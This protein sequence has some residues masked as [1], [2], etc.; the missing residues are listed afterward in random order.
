M[1][2]D[3]M[4]LKGL[5]K[6]DE[7]KNDNNIFRFHYKLTV[8]FLSTFATIISLY[9]PK[10]NWPW[11]NFNILILKYRKQYVGDPIDCY[12]GGNMEM[13]KDKEGAKILDDYC[14]I[15][16]TFTLPNEPGIKHNSEMQLVGMGT[17]NEEDEP[18]I[19]HKYYQ[20]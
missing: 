17:F 12:A 7:I 13:F 2:K 5:F 18:V 15:H 20:V 8:I 16:S 6:I 1:S 11:E 9:W 19:Y 4:A 14:W 3:L 10:L